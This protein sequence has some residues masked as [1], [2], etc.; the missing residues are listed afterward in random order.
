MAY[1]MEIIQFKGL[2]ELSDEEKDVLNEISAEYYPK[3]K[4]EMHNITSIEL[5]VKVHSKGGSKK[6][7]T[8]HLR[9]IAPTRIFEAEHHDWDLPRAL[10]RAFDAMIF[11]LLKAF[12]KDTDY[13]KTHH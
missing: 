4:R 7:Y 5:H 6:K 9:V 8:A 13:H 11:E 2:K 1:V 12:K 10:R 3:I